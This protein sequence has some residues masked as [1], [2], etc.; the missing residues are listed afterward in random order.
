MPH[1]AFD[2][3]ANT[4]APIFKTFRAFSI[5]F[6]VRAINFLVLASAV[7]REMVLVAVASITEGNAI[8]A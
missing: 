5:R 6:L 7:N 1:M 3:R 2:I 4:L 8:I